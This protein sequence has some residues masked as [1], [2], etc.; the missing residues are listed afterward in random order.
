[1]S[2]TK[3][4]TPERATTIVSTMHSPVIR[5]SIDT[6]VAENLRPLMPDGKLIQC[7]FEYGKLFTISLAKILET[8]LIDGKIKDNFLNPYEG[9]YSLLQVC[10]SLGVLEALKVERPLKFDLPKNLEYVYFIYR[11]KPGL[12][13]WKDY[14]MSVKNPFSIVK[15]IKDIKPDYV[16][17]MSMIEAL[18]FFE[19]CD[20]KKFD[21]SPEEVSILEKQRKDISSEFLIPVEHWS[22]ISSCK[23]SGNVWSCDRVSIVDRFPGSSVLRSKEIAIGIFRQFLRFPVIGRKG[24]RFFE[25]DVVVAGGSISKVVDSQCDPNKFPGSD[26]DVFV[27]GKDK[28]ERKKNFEAV[29]MRYKNEAF[30]GAQ[31]YAVNGS[32]VT[33]YFTGTPVKHQI[34][35]TN[36]SNAY[37]V[38]SNFDFTHLQWCLYQGEFLGTPRAYRALREGVT[39]FKNTQYLRFNRVVKAMRQGYHVRKT[40]TIK[41]VIPQI[42]SYLSMTS[43]IDRIVAELNR[44]CVINSSLLDCEVKRRIEKEGGKF[45]MCMAD[46]LKIVRWEGEFGDSYY[47]GKDLKY[48]LNNSPSSVEAKE[49]VLTEKE[50]TKKVMTITLK[51]ELVAQIISQSL[52][53]SIVTLLLPGAVTPL[54]LRIE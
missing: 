13:S 2:L 30:A 44:N 27:I 34:I 7:N 50:D 25:S 52:P 6:E 48:A 12:V 35:A 33:I 18:E 45:C 17:R 47:K 5:I 41:K 9:F 22:P 21:L 51:K 53:G 8:G 36:C 14:F 1:M 46:V 43:Y 10:S 23:N 40:E 16:D 32:V 39:E 15:E 26:I 19:N 11:L 28:E 49:E 4:Y 3:V 42:D 24:G 38:M 29:L 37:E 54:S 20:L 31:Y